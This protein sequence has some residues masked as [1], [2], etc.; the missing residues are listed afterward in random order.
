[1]AS[2]SIA[3]LP[4]RSASPAMWSMRRPLRYRDGTGGQ[5]R[6]GSMARRW[7]ARSWRGSVVNHGYA[8]CCACRRS[9]KRIVVGSGASALLWSRSE[10]C[11]RTGSRVCFSALE[12]GGMSRAEEI[13]VGVWKSFERVV[14]IRCL[15]TSRRCLFRELD[16]LELL[17]EQIKRVEAERDS[18]PATAA[19]SVP[20]AML[21]TI[22]GI[23]P[24]FASVLAGEGLFRHFDNRRQVAAYAGLAPSP[25]CS[26]SIDREQ[27]VSKAGNPR[28]RTAMVQA[29]WLWLA[30]PAGLGPDTLVSGAR[31]SC[32]RPWQ[33][34]RHCRPCPQ[35][36][37]GLLEICDR[38]CRHRRGHRCES[39]IDP[40]E[41]FPSRSLIGSGGSRGADRGRPWLQKPV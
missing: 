10:R 25:W 22:K 37:R 9:R 36:A 19:S 27:G 41:I 33:E 26:G 34:D 7:S 30:V 20:Q 21:A 4:W 11:I 32:R 31:Q 3:R 5:R 8:R 40:A 12:F 13:D 2:G 35:A 23:G 14:V 29:A 18:V 16:R 15:L 6:T 39:L 28:L 17:I 1:M 38:R 24:E